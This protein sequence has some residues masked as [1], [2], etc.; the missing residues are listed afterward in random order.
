MLSA[1]V[2]L[3][4][5]RRILIA[6]LL[7]VLSAGCAVWLDLACPSFYISAEY[8]LRDL[9]ARAGRTAPPNP[10][11]V[12]LAID[13]DSVGLDQSL[14][15][16][17]L[18]SSAAND[19]ECRRA[20]N[21]MTKPWPW[22]RE[23]YAMILQRLVGAGAKL[24]AFDCLFPAPATGDDAFRGA[25]DEFKSQT[26]I[27]ANFVSRT[28]AD[29]TR[30]VPSSYEPPSA[31]LIPHTAA[32]DDRVGFTNFF[33]GEDKVV[34][35][36]QFRVAFRDRE[37]PTASYLSLAA[38]IAAKTGH[39]DK[40][41][42]DFGERLIRFTGPRGV[43]FRPRS[44]FEIFV[45]EYWEHNYGAGEF[46]RNKT[47][48]VGATGKWQKDE[49]GTP[50]GS[51]SGV[52]VHLNALNALTNHEFLREL[53]P[54]EHIGVAVLAAVMG[55]ISSLLIRS[56]W[57]R[58]AALG[59]ID[60][61][62]PFCVLGFYNYGSLYFPCVVPFLALNA[63]M[64]LCFVS[65]FAFE[66]MEKIRLRST[67]KTRDDLTQMIVHDLRSPLTIVKGY[68]DALAQMGELNP[69]E[70]RFIAEAQ[71]GADKMRDMITTLLDLTRLETGQMPLRLERCDIVRIA[72]KAVE[73]FAP[74]AQDRHLDCDVPADPVFVNC[75]DDVIRRVLENL[76][77]NAIKFTKSDG[78][79]S[80]AVEAGDHD[81]TISVSDNGA[82]IPPD[83]HKHIFE[84]FGQTEIGAAKQHSTGIGLAF[85]R[86]AVEAHGGAI[87]VE[88][89]PAKGSR[90]Y[91]SLPLRDPAPAKKQPVTTQV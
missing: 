1:P 88:S 77:S 42:P 74:V 13:S 82:G 57:L 87:G 32:P 64:L 61:A 91:F 89:E 29:I 10:D 86:L 90:F 53:P 26:V 14:D 84:K 37:N 6:V 59:A 31:T 55:A 9:I 71:R 36:I 33:T 4:S 11:L 18:F 54:R 19:P 17:G 34:R 66:Q 69:R 21:F 8:R 67:L 75:D 5:R 12:F 65:D 72:R 83:Q 60:I 51:M 68:V 63:T 7:T 45:P 70:A 62:A 25:L 35:A 49:L 38:R 41:P 3:M 78:T 50:F 20:L 56:P 40:I 76:I 52:E 27:G 23:I 73:R 47:V 80:V 30:S 79:I 16:E 44:I 15:V 43:N 24:I 28:G 46:F 22:A 2:L 58:F 81:A 39:A 48:I 85:C